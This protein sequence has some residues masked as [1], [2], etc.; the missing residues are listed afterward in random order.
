MYPRLAPSSQQ[1]S[2]FSFPWDF[3]HVP[4]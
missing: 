4:A 1:C 3:R 2:C